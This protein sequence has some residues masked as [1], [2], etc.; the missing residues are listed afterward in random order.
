M[1]VRT[2]NEPPELQG[3]PDMAWLEDSV[4]G[5]VRLVSESQSMSSS[6]CIKSLNW[7]VSLFYLRRLTTSPEA[8]LFE[9]MLLL[10]MLLLM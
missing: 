6:Q 10:F 1:F 9:L 8:C 4:V 5:E 7:F 2:W 3:V